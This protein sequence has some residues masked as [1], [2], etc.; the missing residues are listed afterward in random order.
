MPAQH[1]PPSQTD[2]SLPTES[3]K[4]LYSPDDDND[5]DNDDDDDDCVDYDDDDDNGNQNET[6]GSCKA[7][8]SPDDDNN[9]DFDNCVDDD[10]EDD[11]GN[12][13]KRH[14]A[15]LI[16]TMVVTIVLMIMTMEIK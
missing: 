10:D 14:Y 16:M 5:D 4:A 8:C 12:Q 2:A 3:C 15:P 13:N 6:T 9:D 1:R 7:L 11:N